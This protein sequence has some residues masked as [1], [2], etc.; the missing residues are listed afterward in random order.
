MRP[1]HSLELSDGRSSQFSNSV[2]M[3]VTRSE[4]KLVWSHD[5]KVKA[6]MTNGIKS[7]FNHGILLDN[8]MNQTNS[9]ECGGLKQ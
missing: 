3:V 5:E 7:I 6:H 9:E 1:I 2:C 4:W 8:G